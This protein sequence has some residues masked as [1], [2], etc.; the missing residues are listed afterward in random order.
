MPAAGVATFA[1]AAQAVD[2]PTTSTLSS[3]SVVAATAAVS[4]NFA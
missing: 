4:T 1:R 3:A 2:L